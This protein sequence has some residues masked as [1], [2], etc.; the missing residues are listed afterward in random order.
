M[1]YPGG[2]GENLGHYPAPPGGW[3]TI[4]LSKIDWSTINLTAAYKDPSEQ[5][6]DKVDDTAASTHGS[7]FTFTSY[8]EVETVPG[9]VVNGTTP[10]GGL[11]GSSGWY[12]I[13]LNSEQNVLC[14]NISLYNFRGDYSSPA[15]TAT[16]IHEAA[17]GQSGPPRIAFTNPADIGNGVRRSVGCQQGPFK[18]GIVQNGKD[19]AE[20]FHVR[21]IEQNPAGFFADTHSTLAVPGAVRGQ[22]A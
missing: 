16:H 13:A 22:L 6:H 8:Y 20:G 7:P 10:T 1:S 21:Q 2:T 14:Y 18:T 17:R 9:E 4:D 5:G 19:T 12:K 11:A 15:F 3:E